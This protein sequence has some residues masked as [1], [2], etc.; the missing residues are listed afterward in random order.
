MGEGSLHSQITNIGE[1]MCMYEYMHWPGIDYLGKETDNP[2][3]PLQCS[4]VANQLGKERV[5][6]EL[7]GCSG[8]DFSLAGRKRVGDWHIALGVN[9]FCPHLYLY[10][11]R[12]CRKRD[13]PP[14]ISHHQPYWVYGRE[15]EDYFARSNFLMSSGR[16]CANVLVIHPVESGW[17]VYGE[18][19]KKK[20]DRLLESG[21]ISEGNSGI[22]DIDRELAMLARLLS[23]KKF[24]FDFGSEHLVEKYGK[25]EKEVLKVSR[26]TYS[27]VVIPPALTLRKKNA[28]LLARFG[29]K[30]GKIFASVKFPHL[31][32]GEKPAGTLLDDLRKVCVIYD[33]L[34]SLAGFLEKSVERK[35]TVK[36]GKGLNI[37]EILVSA[38]D[39]PGEEE[40]AFFLANTSGEKG[41]SR[42]SSAPIFMALT[43]SLTPP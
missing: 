3:I 25:S 37:P 34:E 35:V 27:A 19:K 9:F 29:K 22:N 14:T 31:L 13:Y 17:C 16:S 5:L 11:L 28:E 24:D 8:Q 33:S 1:A 32:E 42:K 30:G 15:L 39:L 40:T 23:E 26:G 4:S 38:R 10:S 12:G 21:W 41:F 6:S 7:Y 20:A 18:G 43:A 2:L 36:D